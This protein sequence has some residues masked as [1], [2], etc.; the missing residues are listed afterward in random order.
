MDVAA[1]QQSVEDEEEQEAAK[2]EEEKRKK[3]REEELKTT[4]RN[5]RRS[6]DLRKAPT[7]PGEEE[8]EAESTV[9][10]L[11]RSLNMNLF[12]IVIPQIQITPSDVLITSPEAPPIT[13][14]PVEKKG[15]R[16]TRKD[17]SHSHE[18]VHHHHH[19]HHDN[20]AEHAPHP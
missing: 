5:S 10:T 13:P 4:K 7:Q 3:R 17:R 16:M 14:F 8:S 18:H 9:S 19:H 15:S 11:P 2:E 20:Q 1:L 12:S 6:L